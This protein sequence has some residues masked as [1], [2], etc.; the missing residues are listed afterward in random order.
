[1][2][3]VVSSGSKGNAVIYA[4]SIMVDCGVSFSKLKD[5]V[6]DLRLVLLTHI[7]KDHFNIKTIKRLARERPTLRFGACE[8]LKEP[9]QGINNVDIYKIGKVYNYKYF[10]LSPVKLYHDVP[11]CGYRIFLNNYKIF[12]ATDTA[13]L[14][15]ITAK[16]YNL[17]AI[18]HNYND[19]V[20][21][22]NIEK[23]RREG[24]YA[25][26]LGAINSHLSERQAMEFILKNKGDSYE[27]LRL[28]E[29]Q[30]NL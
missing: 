17:Y 10:K 23:A 16:G 1:M 21:M 30:N 25:Y 2:Y 3:K 12:H 7:H 11:N 24:R 13:H 18:E 26:E 6:K 27:I 8:W 20:I 29:S 15:G 9:L 28:H 22:E 19:K 14:K 5:F 4:N